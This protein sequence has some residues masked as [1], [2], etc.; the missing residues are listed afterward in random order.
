MDDVDD[1]DEHWWRALSARDASYAGLFFYAVSSTGVYCRAGCSSRT[2]LRRHVVF[3]ATAT[4]AAGAGFRACRRCRPDQAPTP[5]PTVAAVVALCRQLERCDGVVDVVSFARTV[6]YSERHLRRRFSALV[7]VGVS[8][9]A[10][11][12]RADRVR[13]A[14]AQGASVTT[15]IYEAGYASSRAFYEHGAPRLGMTAS[16]FRSGGR[17]ERIGFTTVRTTLGVV[18]AARTVRGVCAVRIGDDEGQLEKELAEEFPRATVV[19][20]DE[21]LAEVVEI[22]S[23]AVRGEEFS[24]LPLDLAGTAFQRRVWQAL[25]SILRGSTLSYSGVAERIGEP[26]AVRA[27]ASACAAN[28]AALFVPCHRV[29]RRDGSLGGYR[30]GLERKRALLDVES[31]ARTR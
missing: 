22:L 20:D 30:W 2:P 1:V 26:R 18:L 6:G 4:D 15:A 3:F 19:R 21:G 25:L 31:D 16:A 28:P 9:Y 14:L 11:A 13:A 23:D 17:G 12:L 27:V 5:D 7:G 10:R 8:G 29:V 24:P